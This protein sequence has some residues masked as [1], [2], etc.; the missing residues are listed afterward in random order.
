MKNNRKG[1]K[2]QLLRLADEL[3]EDIL[4]ASDE[5]ILAET[6]KDFGD[7]Q[8]EVK[9]TQGIIQQVIMQSGEDRLTAARKILD[10]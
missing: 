9:L 8:A 3:V 1:A 7:V 10:T 4:A 2:R 5:E 6:E